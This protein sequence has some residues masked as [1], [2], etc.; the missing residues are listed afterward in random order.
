VTATT[1]YGK[2]YL[3]LTLRDVTNNL[4]NVKKW[5]SDE[6]ELEDQRK[7]FEIG[8]ILEIDGK[9]EVNY[10]SVIIDNARILSSNEFN[11]DE[12]VILPKIDERELLKCLDETISKI[13]SELLK[14]LLDKIFSD[15]DIKTKFLECPSSVVKHHPYKYGNLEHTIGMIKI[16]ENLEAFYNRNTNLDVDLI[17]TGILLHDIGKI[18]EYYIHNGIPKT[19]PEY[20]LIG[21]LILGDQ[22]VLKFIKEIRDFPKDLENRIRH[23][24]LSHHG[25][26]EWGSPVEPQFPEAEILHYLDMIDSRFK[27]NL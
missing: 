2:P 15:I 18:Y 19:N 23:I 5:L 24:I 9:F 25:R 8:N 17:Y 10:K 4:R 27:L 26:K 22:L 12:F 3:I 13:R 11:L 6:K 21:H 1:K 16:F 7:L 14:K 20:S